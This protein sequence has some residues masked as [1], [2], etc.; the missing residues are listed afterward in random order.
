VKKNVAQ[1]FVEI[2][3]SARANQQHNISR[4]AVQ[5]ILKKIK[6]YPYKINLVQE[7]NENDFDRRIKFC[8][9]MMKKL[10]PTFFLM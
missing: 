1:S 4:M 3:T 5:N 2:F 9:L 6:F 7:L 8:E 10:I